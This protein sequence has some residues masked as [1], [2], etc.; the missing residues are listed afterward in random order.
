MIADK[1]YQVSGNLS[2]GSGR[3]EK[4]VTRDNQSETKN[5]K[6]TTQRENHRPKANSCKKSD[7]ERKQSVQGEGPSNRNPERKERRK[8]KPGTEKRG[9]L[10]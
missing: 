6:K 3:Q 9:A 10:P 1:P 8:E 5:R 2:E 7:S 4:K